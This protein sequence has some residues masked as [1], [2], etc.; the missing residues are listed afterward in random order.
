MR[1]PYA[2]YEKGARTWVRRTPR[3]GARAKKPVL[4]ARQLGAKTSLSHLRL[5][6][7][8]TPTITAAGVIEKI[9]DMLFRID[10]S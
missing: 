4:R 7:A 6:I 10:P 3:L 9:D 5:Y 2:G 1:S 8:G